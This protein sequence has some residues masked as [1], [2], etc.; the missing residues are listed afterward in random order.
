MDIRQEYIDYF[1][2]YNS[3]GQKCATCGVFKI[4]SD[5]RRINIILSNEYGQT[6]IDES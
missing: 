1:D 6:A 5:E 3:V 4:F 2:V